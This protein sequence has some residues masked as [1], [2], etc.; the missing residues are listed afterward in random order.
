MDLLGTEAA[1][2][3]WCSGTD[4]DWFCVKDAEGMQDLSD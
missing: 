1:A 2:R 4:G 3:R